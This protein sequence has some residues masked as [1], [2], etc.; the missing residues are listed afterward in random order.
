MVPALPSMAGSTD[1]PDWTLHEAGLAYTWQENA[2]E[3]LTVMFNKSPIS[4]VDKVIAPIFLMI[5]DVV[6]ARRL[7]SIF[8]SV[9]F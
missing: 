1:I 2:P 4:N 5:G 8:A 7:K 9:W 6:L 3:N